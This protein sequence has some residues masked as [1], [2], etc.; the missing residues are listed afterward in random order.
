MHPAFNEELSQPER[1][2]TAEEIAAI[3]R[4]H[5]STSR[6]YFEHVPG[7]LK[8]G[9]PGSRYKRKR[10]TLRIPESVFKEFVRQRTVKR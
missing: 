9:E 4:M 2:F 7:V 1:Y 8:F 6:R 10:V 3:L 5:P